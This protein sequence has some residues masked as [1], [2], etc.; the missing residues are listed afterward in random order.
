M[1]LIALIPARGGSKG[2]PKKNIKLLSG[3]PLIY[4]T[5]QAA[6]KSKFVDEVVVSTDDKNIAQV[7]KECGA[8]IPFTRPKELASDNSSS[9]SVVKHAINNI[10]NID[11]ILLLQPTSPLRTSE[12]I[13]EV[14]NLQ[15]HS[16]ME[17]VVSISLSS[18]HPAWMFSLSKDNTLKNFYKFK[19]DQRRQDLADIYVLNGSI[20]LATKSFLEINNSFI[21]SAT[22]GY[23]MPPERSVDIDN[24]F[25]WELAEFLMNKRKKQIKSVT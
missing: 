23:L 22:F 4:W 13:D 11:N 8:S 1:A 25:D 14:I 16:Q 7:A 6:L 2:I 10:K 3:K 18:K 19:P 17:S 24:E 21:T 15:K 5:I 12:D 9:M 20:Y